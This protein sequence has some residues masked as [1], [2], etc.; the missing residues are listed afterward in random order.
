MSTAL[1]IA[2]V[3]AVI[4]DLLNNSL[5][6]FD[7]TSLG[8]V[9]VTALPPDR[10]TT[11]TS[12][13]SQLNLFLYHVTP[14]QGW[15]NV[16]LPSRDS[17]GD[18]TS[19]PPLAVNLHYLL[20][21]YGKRDFYC[22]ILLG[23][24]MQLLHE[25]PVL[26]RTAIRNALNPSIPV[27]DPDLAATLKILATAGLEEQIEQIKITP[28]SLSTEEMSRLWATFQQTNYRATAAY[29]AS[30]VLIESRRS[31]KSAL[32]VRQTNL[33]VLPFHQP[34]ITDVSPNIVTSESILTISGENL[35]AEGVVV[36]FNT[37]VVNPGSVS[38]HTLEVTVPSN[39]PSGVNTVQVVHPLYF[40]TPADP[41]QGFESNVAA[42]I[43][44][45][46]IDK[47]PDGTYKMTLSSVLTDAKGTYRTV[48]IE[49][50][51][52]VGQSQRVILLLNEWTSVAN[53]PPAKSYS[54]RATSRT[55][56]TK[57]IE[58]VIRDVNPRSYLVRVQ[59]DGAESLPDV[60]TDPNSPN[61]NRYTGTPQLVIPT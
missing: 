16:G 15:R 52:I 56:N 30:V 24:G 5:K 18:R 55:S 31:T 49:L 20:T 42:F 59:V 9:T 45:P 10:I 2:A 17:N 11:G 33:R 60:N 50:T 43:L 27:S 58:F 34:Q 37:R 41:H 48:T 36:K 21:A 32:P 51:P 6:N 35:K 25:M 4:K 3:T 53:P 26:T 14:N 19:N 47:N 29:Q 28:E 12:E 46:T 13:A 1:A 23:Y 40:D 39:L 54:F 44:R 7:L 22:D 57:S 61:F 38:D 8:D